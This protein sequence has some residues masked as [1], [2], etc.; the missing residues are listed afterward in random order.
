MWND[1][2]RKTENEVPAFLNCSDF[3]QL[4]QWVNALNQKNSKQLSIAFKH[5]L[6]SVLSVDKCHGGEETWLKTMKNEYW[7]NLNMHNMW[8]S[9][10][11]LT[12][13]QGWIHNS[14]HF[15]YLKRKYNV[16]TFLDQDLLAWEQL[17]N[18]ATF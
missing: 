15:V 11:F 13:F 7:K 3:W 2:L 5:I 17:H 8:L 14:W 12:T 16:V 1:L 6:D 18:S 9:I 10:I 4:A